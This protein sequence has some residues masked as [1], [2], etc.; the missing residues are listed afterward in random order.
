MKDQNLGPKIFSIIFL[1]LIFFGFLPNSA[2]AEIAPSEYLLSTFGY[3]CPRMVQRSNELSMQSF[4]DL[5]SF[6][7]QARNNPQCQSQALY[8]N[9]YAR[10]DT[11]YQHRQ[12]ELESRR[13]AYLIDQKA[14]SQRYSSFHQKSAQG[15][16]EVILSSSA[17]LQQDNSST[18]ACVGSPS[19]QRNFISQLMMTAASLSTGGTSL[20]LSAGSLLLHD[21]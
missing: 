13:Q 6:F 14:D 12:E 4:N 8:A 2:E 7:V 15:L 9:L 10:F 20:A 3:R 18:N 1:V 21:Q 17:L 19:M 5:R 11:I 16:Q